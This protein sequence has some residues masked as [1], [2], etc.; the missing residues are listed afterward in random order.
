MKRPRWLWV[1]LIATALV[2]AATVAS[3]LLTR[4][5]ES[6]AQR[7][8][9]VAGA[10]MIPAL[11]LEARDLAGNGGEP[12]SESE[13]NDPA[14]DVN[15]PAMDKFLRQAVPTGT[16]PS[17]AA[18]VAASTWQTYGENKEYTG[19]ANNT[20]N[21]FEW[22]LIGPTH[23]TQPGVLSFSGAQF[24]MAGRVTAMINTPVCTTNSN[25]RL[26]IAA[27]GGGIWRTDNPFSPD[28]YWVFVSIG[29][30]T[31]AI[32]TIDRDPNDPSGNTL[33]AGTGEPNASGDSESG[34]GIYKTTDGG[35]HW[36]L[37]PGST[38]FATRSISKVVVDPRNPN[39]LYVGVARGIR[40]Y[41]SVT[42]GAFSRTGPCVQN[43]VGGLGCGDGP[44]QAPLGLYESTDGGNTFTLAWDANGSARG[45]NDVGLDPSDSTCVYVAAFQRGLWRSCP[46]VDGSPT[47]KQ[48]FQPGSPLQN[49]DR[50]QFDLTTVPAG[51]PG[52][53][54]RIYVVDGAVGPVVVR[55][56]QVSFPAHVWRA[57]GANTLTAAA[58]LASQGDPVTRPPSPNSGAGW[59]K[60]STNTSRPAADPYR[61]AYN[62]CTGQCW[63]DE[64]IVTPKGHPDI[65]YVLGSYQYTERHERSNGR[66]VL[67]STTAG[68]PDPSIK[69]GNFSDLTWDDTPGAQPDQTHPDQH[70]IAFASDNPFLYFEGS[71]GGMIRSDGQ[72]DDASADCA[73]YHVNDADTLVHCERVL[74]RVPHQLFDTLNKGLSTLQFQS[75]S[76]DPDQPQNDIQGGTQDN[77]TFDWD[78]QPTQWNEEIYGDGGQSGFNYCDSK[79]RFNTFFGYYTD[80][81]FQNG[82]PDAWYVTSGPLSQLNNGESQS[83]YIPAVTDYTNCGP[84]SKFPQFQ[85]E[86]ARLANTNL[87]AGGTIEGRNGTFAAT[88][89]AGQQLGAFL[90]FQYAGE[91]HVWRTVDNGGPEA[92]LQTCPEFTTSGDD[93]RCGD[94]QPLGD[95]AYTA[96][97]HKTANEPG[98]LTSDQ[99]GPDRRGLTVVAT[100]RNP[101]NNNEL[102][103]ATG[104]GRVFVSFNV[105]NVDP[106]TV[107]FCRLDQLSF[108]AASPNAVAP[109]RF[110]SSIY[111]DPAN[112]NRAWLSYNGYNSNTKD[113]PGHVFEVTFVG[114][115]TPTSPCPTAAVWRDLHVEGASAT[116]SDP[117]GDIPI[118][119]LVRDDFTGDLF[120]S[121]DFGVLRDAGGRDGTWTEAGAKLPRVEVPGLT[122]DPC[123]RL[124]YAATH[125][126]SVWRMYLPAGAKAKNLK[127]CPRTP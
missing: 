101:G 22:S 51:G 31:N 98:D 23:A 114:A 28:P 89:A 39:H 90:G 38:F 92:Y 109:P 78:G 26:W 48:V 59:A 64:D 112:P 16:I 54:T 56:V 96:P 17:N 68:D 81:N 4:G 37:L 124:L 53:G 9:R 111:P 36:T 3:V 116:H 126:R 83:F 107:T 102:W 127:G 21:P 110:V 120:A 94:W 73:R 71:D 50:T 79:I 93:P 69:G 86:A 87:F 49:T 105:N 44:E 108:A 43:P 60:K 77:G 29:F 33:Y 47:F 66:G 12:D 95:P 118:T 10:P 67:L 125:G 91:Q 123:S 34:V 32:G 76:V 85:T 55:D 5:S 41:A 117:A 70:A 57:D 121:T 104:F 115:T 106:K 103:A 13:G 46:A 61:P 24:H 72:F 45:V 63:Y 6:D 8:D 74:S 88:P 40:G 97:G 62:S 113:Q 11:K 52:A 14:D 20:N 100:E 99:Y 65:V 7:V 84:I 82:K 27:A 122:I 2:A 30:R 58:L 25:C 119:D 42:G 80:E 1:G 15:G 35:D 75:V 18:Q 19:N